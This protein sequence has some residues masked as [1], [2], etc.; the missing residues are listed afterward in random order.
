MTA[1]RTPID[2]AHLRAEA[3]QD[4]ADRLRVMDRLAEAELHLLLE[5]ADDETATPRLFEI[6]GVRYA[7]AFDLPDR[8]EAFAGAAGMAVLS[9][10][11]LAPLLSS[12]GLGLGLNLGDGDDQPPSAQLLPPEAV[13]WLAEHLERAPEAALARIEEVAPPGA[14]P[15]RLIEALDAKLPAMAGLARKAYLVSAAYEG[16]ARGHVLGVID[17]VPGAEDALA[18][19]VQEAMAFSGL[20]AGQIDVTFLRASNPL[21]ASLARHGLRID[22]PVPDAPDGPPPPGRDAPPRLR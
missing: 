17:P 11:A 18:R 13:A 14:L 8:L 10:R 12:E 9:G 1:P 6:D 16:G 19:A 2:T 21:A 20:D 15:D 22:L 4:E 7:L 3:T 5:G